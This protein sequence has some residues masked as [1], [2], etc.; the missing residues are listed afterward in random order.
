VDKADVR[1]I[2]HYNLPQ[3]IEAYYQEAGRA[4]RDGLPARCILLYAAA[5]KGQLTTWL[6]EELLS[7][8]YL[9][10]V[11]RALRARLGDSWGVIAIDDLRRDLREED[12]TRLRVALG[13]LERVGLVARHFDLPRAATLLLRQL[14]QENDGVGAGDAFSAFVSLARLRLGQPLDVDLLDLAARAGCAPD[15]LESRLLRWHDQGLL[16]YDGSARDALLHLPPAPADAG[17]RLDALL[18]E[19]ATRQDERIDA[20]A[21]YARRANCR[22]RSIA[23]HFGERLVRCGSSC[24]ICAPD[25]TNDHRPPTTDRLET[26]RQGDK[27]TRRRRTTDYG[28]RTTDKLRTTHH[29]SRNIDS[30]ILSCLA[31]LPFQV[32]R[33]GLAKVLK[34]AAGSPIGP[35][36]CP[37][38]AALGGMTLAAIEA[39]IEQ[40]VERGYLARHLH[41]RMPLLALTDRGAAILAED[42]V[43]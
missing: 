21:A 30:I 29:A 41:G 12:E 33:S 26:R 38:Y 28:L 6:R 42:V 36:R 39:A 15:E 20:I 2:V 35:D 23:A 16:R 7:K 18:A 34:G 25:T 14:P 32:G 5:D 37:D 4:G 3:S 11:Y 19:Y 8:E 27:E 24:D 10:Q 40:L 22:H 43:Q 1:A 17:D 31:R 9:R 13:L